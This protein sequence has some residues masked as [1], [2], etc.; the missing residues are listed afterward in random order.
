MA[1]RG[2]TRSRNAIA[3]EPISRPTQPPYSDQSRWVVNQDVHNA[4]DIELVLW[5]RRI[6][7]RIERGLRVERGE[8]NLYSAHSRL[9]FGVDRAHAGDAADFD[10]DLSFASISPGFVASLGLKRLLNATR[11]SL[12][13]W[14]LGAAV[15]GALDDPLLRLF[16]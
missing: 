4:T 9:T 6:Q 10:P 2:S 3:I 5:L 1:R 13:A 7:V 11:E 16:R 14:V 12:M 8:G 15:G